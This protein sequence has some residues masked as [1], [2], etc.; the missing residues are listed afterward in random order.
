MN[1]AQPSAPEASRIQSGGCPF[2]YAM[3]VPSYAT[4]TI[5]YPVCDHPPVGK[6]VGHCLLCATLPIS[7]AHSWHLESSVHLLCVARRHW[8][9]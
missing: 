7:H 2:P 4:T 8:V 9:H 5:A 3:S 6:V 1:K